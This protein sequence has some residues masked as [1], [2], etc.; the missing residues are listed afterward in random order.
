MGKI[1]PPL[2]EQQRQTLFGGSS[3]V[4]QMVANLNNLISQPN[5]GGSGTFRGGEGGSLGN[6]NTGWV[7]SPQNFKSPALLRSLGETIYARTNGNTGLPN[8]QPP[9]GIPTPLLN[10]LLQRPLL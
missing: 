7:Q 5:S 1:F 10:L 8:S 9:A 4:T 2:V 6:H 3:L